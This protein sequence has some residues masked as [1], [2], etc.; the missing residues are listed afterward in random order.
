M[1][2]ADAVLQFAAALILLAGSAGASAWLVDSAL[3]REDGE[4]AFWGGFT[5]VMAII[6][7][8][9]WA[10]LAAPALAPLAGVVLLVSTGAA[11]L[12]LRRRRLRRLRHRQEQLAQ[13]RMAALDGR[14]RLVLSQWQAYELDPFKALERPELT[15]VTQPLTSSLIRAMRVAEQARDAALAN[16][17]EQ[18]GYARAVERLEDAWR[19]LD[20]GEA[21]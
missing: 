21:A 9:V 7:C 20:D 14:H 18:G 8:A 16:P 4:R 5:G 15:D 11:G 1:G 17:A 13:R 2:G 12:W 6:L 10:V 3:R 19:R